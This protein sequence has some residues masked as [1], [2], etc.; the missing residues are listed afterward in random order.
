MR[1]R[2]IAL[3]VLPAALSAAGAA[4][5]GD[6]PGSPAIQAARAQDLAA[7]LLAAHNRERTAVRVPPLRWDPAL[8]DAAAGYA[9]R[10][11]AL[12]RLEHSPRN[13]RPGQSENLWM[14]SAGAYSPEQMVANWARE[15]SWFRP[16]VFPNVSSTGD[17][18]D[19]SHYTQMIWPTTTSVGC[20]VHRRGRNDYLI[21]R[22]APRGNQDG[23]R[24]P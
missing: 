4:A 3:I 13:A 6:R 18:M 1:G 2:L 12:G 8:A 11:A 19:V 10:L 5:G 24:V 20:A 23:R 22:Y 16:G 7:R 9:P 15:K 21:C 17:W 14:G